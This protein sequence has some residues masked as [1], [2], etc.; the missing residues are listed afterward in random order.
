MSEEEI[1]QQASPQAEE[2]DPSA[3]VLQIVTDD[4]NCPPCEQ[5]KKHLEGYKGKV[6]IIN[7]MEAEEEFWQ[8]DSI[9]LPTARVKK[10]DGSSVPCEIFMDDKDMVVKCEGKMLVVKAA[11]RE[12]VEEL[13]AIQE[14]AQ[15]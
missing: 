8:G 9:E 14:Q 7:V 12:L 4:E 5:I 6:E 15:P 11:P 3:V 10:Q 2:I 13:E 1:S